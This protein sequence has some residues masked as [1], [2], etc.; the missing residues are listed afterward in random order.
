MNVAAARDDQSRYS[1]LYSYRT[2]SA[3]L[4]RL[5]TINPKLLTAPLTNS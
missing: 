1:T 2:E 4:M 5:F 3:G